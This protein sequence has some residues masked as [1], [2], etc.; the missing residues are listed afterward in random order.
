MIT[1]YQDTAFV[2]KNADRVVGKAHDNRIS[3]VAG[4]EIMRE[5]ANKGLDVT[6][7]LIGTAQEEVG[8]RGAKTSAHK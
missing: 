1:P 5:L 8:L 6:V 7:I 3:A 2:T 4:I